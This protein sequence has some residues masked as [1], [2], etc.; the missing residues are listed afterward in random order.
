MTCVAIEDKVTDLEIQCICGKQF[1]FGIEMFIGYV[2]VMCMCVFFYVFVQKT[3]TTSQVEILFSLDVVIRTTTR[4]IYELAR[5]IF[6]M[7]A[8]AFASTEY[9]INI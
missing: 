9:N 3:T 1:R 5:Q 4:Q 6:S 2:I 7:L 8:F